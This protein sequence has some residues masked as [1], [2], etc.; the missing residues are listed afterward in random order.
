MT[1]NRIIGQT[2]AAGFQVGVRRSF[3]ISQEDAWSLLTLSD[4]LNLWLGEGTDISLILG[5]TYRTNL[6][7]GEIR[8]VKPLEQ[9]RLT[10]QKKDGRAHRQ[11]K[12]AFFQKQTIKQRLAFIKKSYQINM[13]EKK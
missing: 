9:L 3:S 10:W 7:S 6:G 2:K 1:N 12:F 8:I 5:Q 4:G 11:F 13:L